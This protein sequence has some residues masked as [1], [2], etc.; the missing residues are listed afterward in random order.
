MVEGER[1]EGCG[2]GG[3]VSG[4]DFGVVVLVCVVL[5]SALFCTWSWGV[6]KRSRQTEKRKNQRQKRAPRDHHRKTDDAMR[7]KRRRDEQDTDVR[8][9]R[10]R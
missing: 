9:I 10:V 4:E 2:V 1:E 5:C 3:W 6:P 8:K 7:T